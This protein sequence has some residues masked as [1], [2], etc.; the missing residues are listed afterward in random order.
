MRGMNNLAK[1][2][3]RKAMQREHEEVVPLALEKHYSVAE[4]A[5]LW[6]VNYK[7]VRKIFEAEKGIL[8]WGRP[9]RGAKRGYVSMRIPQSVMIRVHERLRMR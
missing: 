1:S 8:S 9:E 5:E 4:I 7:T 3:R 2:L 6:A